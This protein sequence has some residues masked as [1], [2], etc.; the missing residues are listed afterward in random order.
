MEAFA[1]ACVAALFLL[2]VGIL[3]FKPRRAPVASE[4][5]PARAIRLL[6]T[7]EPAVRGKLL[8]E[9]EEWGRLP[10]W[11]WQDR[12]PFGPMPALDKDPLFLDN[13]DPCLLPLLPP[14]RQAHG[15][16]AAVILAGGNYEILTPAEAEPVAKW[17]VGALSIPACVLKYRLLPKHGLA[18]MVED[19]GAAVLEARRLSG[20]GPVVTIGFSAG[21]HLSAVGCAAAASADAKERRPDAQV[22]V[23]PSLDATEWLD[24]RTACFFRADV[25]SP[26]VRSLA[27][28]PGSLEKLLAPGPAFVAPPPTFLVASVA[29]G[30][31]HP[32]R[33]ADAYCRAARRAGA[34]LRYMRADFGRHG[35]GFQDVWTKPCIRWLRDQGFGP[36]PGEGK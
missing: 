12:K 5:R 8:L 26:Q 36:A 21:A 9:R 25:A 35:F 18:E 30:T 23:Y 1:I 2:L 11:I 10:F 22:L 16:G 34:E 7:P 17:V 28:G 15:S 19:L 4:A 3:V 24:A 32:E 13:D 27:E 14:L 29:D 20:G 6:K 31:C 33:H